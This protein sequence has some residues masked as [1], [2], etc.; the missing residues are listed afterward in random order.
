MRDPGFDAAKSERRRYRQTLPFVRAERLIGT[1]TTVWA[2]FKELIHMTA[3]DISNYL[4]RLGLS[5]VPLTAYGL[6]QLQA[7][8]IRNIPF[9]NIDPLLGIEP[10]VHI[11]SVA[12]KILG[13][14]RGGYCFELNELYRSALEALGF[15]V[16]RRLAR[17]RMGAATGGPR[18]HLAIVCTIDGIRYLTDAGFGGPA[19]L[20]PLRADD[21][22][23][24]HA[25]NGDY[26]LVTDEV[27][28]E[29][30]LLRVT[31]GQKFP[32]YGFDEAYVGDPDIAAANYL[33]TTWP[34]SPFPAHLMVNGYDGDSRIGIFDRELTVESRTAAEKQE[35]ATRSD[36]EHV[37]CHRLRL[38]IDRKTL[39]DV[40]GHI[41]PQKPAS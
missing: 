33:C 36:L 4:A 25:P 10:Q 38:K 30:V 11:A 22:G 24:Q 28:G 34:Q 2:W 9:E 32:L 5:E 15:Q 35:L 6:A 23:T 12:K 29:R 13:G 31:D 7:A 14:R 20:H 19:P 39:E 16:E 27:S 37:L 3:F 26:R 40:W 18:T 1:P 8:H 17:V 21:D 41:S